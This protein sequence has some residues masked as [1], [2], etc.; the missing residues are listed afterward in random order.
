VAKVQEAINSFPTRY[1]AY[2]LAGMSQKI[3]LSKAGENDKALIDDLLNRMADNKADFTLTF[4]HL[5]DASADS[6]D[7]DQ[8]VRDLFTDSADF[9]EWAAQW[10]DRLITESASDEERQ[11]QMHQV[12]PLYIPR[13]HLVEAVIRAGEDRL[14]FEPFYE[15]MNVL[16]HPYTKQTGMKKYA[17]P[18]VAAEVVHQTFCG[19]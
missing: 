3:G 2:W 17:M 5:S 16:K 14:D 19:T 1:E 4:Y 18:P 15:L 7:N 12:N 8:A 10:R 11:Q 6:T 9:D 13:N